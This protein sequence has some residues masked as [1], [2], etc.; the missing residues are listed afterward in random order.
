MND[1]TIEGACQSFPERSAGAS[2]SSTDACAYAAQGA[3]LSFIQ[4]ARM[5]ARARAHAGMH[6][7][8][9][10]LVAGAR[11]HGPG[12]ALPSASGQLRAVP[13]G[14]HARTHVGRFDD[15]T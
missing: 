9:S 11:V 8:D 7:A 13:T 12:F 5:H 3:S 10:P 2:S 6:A 15:E 1:H 14:L 4:F